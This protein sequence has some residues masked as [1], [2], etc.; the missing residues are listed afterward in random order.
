MAKKDQWTVAGMK[1]LIKEN[2]PAP[3]NS[4]DSAAVLALIA[5][6]P[7]HVIIGPQDPMPPNTPANR[8]VLRT[9]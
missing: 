2:A 1:R 5:A 9:T 8:L 7:N 4:V 6:N 3:S